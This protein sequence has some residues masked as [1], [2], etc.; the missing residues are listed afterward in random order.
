[1]LYMYVYIYIY[2]CIR[3]RETYCI[4]TYAIIR[5][6]VYIYYIYDVYTNV[7]GCIYDSF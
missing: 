3:E 1:M 4:D 7:F 5:T 2:V 6:Y